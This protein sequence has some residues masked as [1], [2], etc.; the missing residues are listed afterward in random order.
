MK[1]LS[2]LPGNINA[3]YPL[4]IVKQ[5]DKMAPNSTEL[6]TEQESVTNYLEP[7]KIPNKLKITAGKTTM[8]SPG[9]YLTQVQ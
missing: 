6:I 7:G 1:T 8:I 4:Y 9:I 5:H 3:Q 2:A